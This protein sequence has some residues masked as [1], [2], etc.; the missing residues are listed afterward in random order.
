MLKNYVK[1]AFRNLLKQNLYSFINIFSLSLGIA[2]CIIIYL[3][4]HDEEGFDQFNTKV[5]HIYRLE[6]VQSFTGT[7]VQNVALSMPGMGPNLLAEFPEVI[8]YTRFWGRGKQ[9]YEFEDKRITIEKT[10]AVDSTFLKIFDFELLQG[11]KNTALDEPNTIVLTQETALKLFPSIDE[12]LGKILT[13]SS[14]T[15][16]VT[17]VCENVP[18]NSH[19]QFDALMSITT[20]TRENQEFNNRW[21]SNF[22]V[23]YLELTDDVDLN[24]MH[25]K[26]PN[27][28]LK[29]MPA[30]EGETDDVNDYYKLYVKSLSDVHLASTQVE[31]DYHNYRKFNGS[32]INIFKIAGVFIL[33]IACFNF[34]NLTTARASY[35]WKEVGV[36]KSIGAKYNQLFWQF[37][38]E[39]LLLAFIALLFAFAISFIFTPVINDAIGRSMNIAHLFGNWKIVLLLVSL[40]IPLGVLSGIYPS[41]ILTSVKP[42]MILKGGAMKG[43]KNLFQNSLVVVQFGLAIS[44]IIS[45]LVVLQQIKFINSKDL[46]FDKD[47]IVL[48]DMN[49]NANE[50]F[51]TL[52][53]ELQTNPK[54]LGVT[55]SG[56]RIGNNFHQWGY[57]VKTD[58]AVTNY[59]P[60]NV[61]VD[62]DFLKVYGIDLLE[63]RD[64]DE[65]IFT[66]NG[67]AFIINESL[68]KDLGIS[69]D[70]IV[71]T[72]A[73]HSW[74]HEDSL[75]AIIGVV[76]DFNFNSLHYKI[77]TL[78]MVVHSEW[79]YSECSIK[80]SGD[81]IQE[82][83][84]E[85]ERT[86]TAQVP[87]W[88]FE[89]SFLDDHFE[90]L[91]RSDQ[92]MSTVVSI[93]AILSVLIAC[94]GLFGLAAITT[95]KRTKEIG[96]RKVLG[97]NLFQINVV[98]AKNFILLVLVSFILFIPL[99]VMLLNYWLQNFAYKVELSPI[100]FLGGGII[101]I[102]IALATVSYHTIRSALKNP[103]DTLRYE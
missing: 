61:N 32:Y 17:G 29:H 37:I 12:A 6:E 38:L 71:G 27:F 103:V 19:L 59:T 54:V 66:D 90:E 11:D 70:K 92:Q 2:A 102:L 78:S 83:L 51:T 68:A 10:V 49:G 77:N 23:T 3:F 79:G 74:Y 5:D 33:L 53:N 34:M 56:Q 57:K 75:G 73:G 28:L 13:F 18:E 69:L 85:I 21:G 44:M 9:L 1:I 41:L 94:M 101:S 20:N 48:I 72:P 40:T 36:R 65:S 46:G 64:F 60:S 35:R 52:K 47:Q 91:Y 81:D 25:S 87:D 50:S 97:A 89:Y 95:E 88:P 42:A 62:F 100:I 98:L 80:I 26:F 55:A 7:N 93:M 45:T 67:L 15:L 99:T 63:G 8:N 58:T 4:V 96:I 14:S 43:G 31:H 39:S 30:D 86:W 84:A 24:N 82:T 76:K 16:K 22:L